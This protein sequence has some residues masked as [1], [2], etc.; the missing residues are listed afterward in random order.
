[1]SEPTDAGMPSTDAPKIE[2]GGGLCNAS[3]PGRRSPAP[4]LPALLVAAGALGFLRSRRRA[5]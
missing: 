5:N 3:L 4:W 1:M 2:L